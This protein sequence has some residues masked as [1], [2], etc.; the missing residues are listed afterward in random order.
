MLVI[1]MEQVYHT[2]VHFDIPA[3]N[4]EKM[5]KFYSSLFSW[6][7]ERVAGPIEYYLIETAPKGK[8]VGGGMPKKEDQSQQ[9]MNY[10]SVE[11]VDEYSKKVKELGGK[12]IMPKQTVPGMGH[13]AVAI[14]PE[15]NIFGLWEAIS[16]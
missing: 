1:R 16:P 2:I 7:I 11:S 5:R 4:V 9:P 14:D 15:R 3:E 8:G 10:Y 13:F 12:I 6:K